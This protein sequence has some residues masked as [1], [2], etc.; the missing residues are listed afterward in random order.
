MQQCNPV[1]VSPKPA[2]FA[3]RG[4][5]GHTQG[6]KTMSF[7]QHQVEQGDWYKVE[8]DNGTEFVPVDVVG[9]IGL[10]MGEESDDETTLDRIADYCE[11][12]PQSVKLIEGWGVRLLAPGYMDCTEW[13]VFET[14]EEA[15]EMYGDEE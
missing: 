2:G 9:G 4:P 7:M 10:E 1:R 12:R 6:K 3:R 13:T 8:T 11:G 5:K 14:E 15:E